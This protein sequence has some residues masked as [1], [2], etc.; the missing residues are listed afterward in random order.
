M[1]FLPPR[2]IE[3]LVKRDEQGGLARGELLRVLDEI[4]HQQLRFR[5]DAVEIAH[6]LGVLNDKTHIAVNDLNDILADVLGKQEIHDNNSDNRQKNHHV[7][8]HQFS[9]DAHRMK[10]RMAWHGVLI[11]QARP[12]RR[13]ERVRAYFA[14]L[15]SSAPRMTLGFALI[16]KR[17]MTSILITRRPY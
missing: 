17:C 6:E 9:A 7:Q 16:P 15:T 8:R 13:S 14:V 12:L 11:W 5:K 2:N 3:A 10:R 1:I 4:R